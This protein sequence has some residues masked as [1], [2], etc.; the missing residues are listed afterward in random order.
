MRSLR[1]RG[2]IIRQGNLGQYSLDG[3]APLRRQ[4]HG[5]GAVVVVLPGVDAERLVDGGG[6]FARPDLALA[7]GLAVGVG[8]TVHRAATDA[9]AG[10]GTGPGTGEVVAAHVLVDD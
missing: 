5:P 8:L 10:E 2:N 4:R 1:T 6:D 3:L 9:A 7:D